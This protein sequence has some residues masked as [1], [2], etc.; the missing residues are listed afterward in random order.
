MRAPHA[1]CSTGSLRAKDYSRRWKILRKHPE[2]LSQM[3]ENV[4]PLARPG[5]AERAADVLEEA[6]EKK[7]A[8]D[9]RLLCFALTPRRKAETILL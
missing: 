3:R 6:A 1:W 8:A 2:Q 9:V 7:N 5:A 4:R